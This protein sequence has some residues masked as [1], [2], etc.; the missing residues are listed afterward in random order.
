MTA[1]AIPAL[2]DGFVEA[3]AARQTVRR[4]LDAGD[5]ARRVHDAPQ[6]IRREQSAFGAD[7]LE[8]GGATRHFRG[9]AKG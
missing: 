6:Q 5:F 7:G 2:G 1:E 9:K 4:G 3:F 8:F